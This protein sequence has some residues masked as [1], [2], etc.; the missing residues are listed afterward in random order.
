MGN[1]IR[2]PPRSIRREPTMGQMI[3]YDREHPF[4]L[5]VRE[6]LIM[7]VICMIVIGAGIWAIIA[8]MT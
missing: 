1:V 4:V 3:N 6:Q 5:G 2:M 8:V 7:G